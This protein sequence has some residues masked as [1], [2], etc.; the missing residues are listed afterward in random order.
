[1]LSLHSGVPKTPHAKLKNENN[2]TLAKTVSKTPLPVHAPGK[3]TV[4]TEVRSRKGLVDKTPGKHLKNRGLQLQVQTLDGKSTLFI[5]EK[6]ASASRK[7]IKQ[8]RLSSTPIKT[9]QNDL[10]SKLEAPELHLQEEEDLEPEYMPP[11]AVVPPI[12][13]ED[14]GLMSGTDMGRVLLELDRIPF[15]WY[16]APPVSFKEEA[17]L[18]P[19]DQLIV[20]LGRLTPDS[21][22]SEDD[23]GFSTSAT[24]VHI[25]EVSQ[26][27]RT[28]S[29][30]PSGIPTRS[31]AR[32]AKA[33]AVKTSTERTALRSQ[34]S[35]I[36]STRSRG[37]LTTSKLPA[38][39][40]KGK[41]K[42][43]AEEDDDDDLSDLQEYLDRYEDPIDEFYFDV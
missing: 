1:M 5:E 3:A 38:P 10:A 7:S 37:N 4:T 17:F 16:C 12:S 15:H 25:P 28:H 30:I 9:V 11:T 23:V 40:A 34:P 41:D 32:I 35:T 19:E 39:Q 29:R 6:P 33:A 22:A 18:I 20:P 27:K 26:S 14:F 8:P 13:G 31:S 42:V 24:A 43:P 21:M 36:R 2:V